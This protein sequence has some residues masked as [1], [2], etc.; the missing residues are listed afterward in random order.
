MPNVVYHHGICIRGPWPG[1]PGSASTETGQSVPTQTPDVARQYTG[2]VVRL[3]NSIAQSQTGG[4]LLQFIQTGSDHRRITIGPDL[5]PVDK[6]DELPLSIF[7]PLG[8]RQPGREEQ[9]WNPCAYGKGRDQSEVLLHELVHAYRRLTGSSNN[10]IVPYWRDCEEFFAIMI[11]NMYSSESGRKLRTGFNM[12]DPEFDPK[13]PD[14]QRL[15]SRYR[16]AFNVIISQ[17]DLF[18]RAL[19]SLTIPFNPF[20]QLYRT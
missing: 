15:T 18:S 7:F 14:V 2:A 11:T 20:R 12:P 17:N 10:S 4:V 6:V 5:P 1:N 16:Y 19:A 9:I 3:L 13:N 8:E